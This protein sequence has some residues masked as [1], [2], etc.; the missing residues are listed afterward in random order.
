[1]TEKQVDRLTARRYA[2]RMEMGK[3]AAADFKAAVRTLLEKQAYVRVVFAAAP[4]QDEFLDAIAADTEIFFERMDA[5]HMDEYIGLPQDAPQGFGNFL[6]RGIFS[7]RAFRSVSYINGQAADPEVECARYAA[8]LNEG[9]IDA[10]CMG[11]GE[12]GHIAFNDP[13]VADFADPLDV[14]VVRLDDVCRMQQVHDG[15]FTRLSDVPETAISLT[16]PRLLRAKYHFCV[17]PGAMKA[18]AVTHMLRDEIS[19]RCP[20]SALR[21]CEHA[22]LYLDAES[23]ARW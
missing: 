9:E 19:V 1:M 7:R 20:A 13:P 16:V 10:I 3:A 5:F 17:V 18:D 22:V 8:L 6:Y 23:G 15:C 11:I 21:T 4:S 14:K 2:S 12:N